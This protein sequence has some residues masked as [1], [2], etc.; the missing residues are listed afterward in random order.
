[1]PNPQGVPIDRRLHDTDAGY[2][3][4]MAC[5]N[6]GWGG[7]IVLSRGIEVPVPSESRSECPGCGCRSLRKKPNPRPAL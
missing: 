2:F 5:G 3:A 4:E 7:S 1:M 6:C